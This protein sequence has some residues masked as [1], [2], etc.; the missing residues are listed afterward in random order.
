MLEEKARR[1]KFPKAVETY[2]ARLFP[3]QIAFVNDPARRKLVHAGRRGGKTHALVA[4]ILRAAVANPGTVVPVFERTTVCRA[5]DVLW[6]ALRD[7][8]DEFGLNWEFQQTLKIASLPNGCRVVIMGADTAEAADK[9]RGDGYPLVVIDEVGTF[10]QEI[11]AFL[12]KEALGPGLFD[13]G[14]RLVMAGTPNPIKKGFFFECATQG[15]WAVHHWTVLDNDSLPKNSGHLTSAERLVLRQAALALTLRE[16]SWTPTS[17]AY[18]REY[19]GQW[20]DS[21]DDRM[22][23][24]GEANLID[25]LPSAPANDWTYTL[26]IDVG[27]NDPCALVVLGRIDRDPNLYVIESYE[28]TELIP[29]ALAQHVLRLQ[30]RYTFAKMVIDTGGAG[31]GYAQE[32]RQ[33]FQLNVEPAKK[34]NKLANIEF[35]NGD[36]RTGRVKILR[37]GNKAL[38]EDLQALPWNDTKTDAAPRHRDHLPDAFLYG[39]GAVRAWADTTAARGPLAPVQGSDAWNKAQDTRMFELALAGRLGALRDEYDAVDE[40]GYDEPEDELFW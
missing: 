32:M 26:G 8:S 40:E 15:G 5:A 10:R 16:N 7:F 38:I 20:S 27:Y 31:I 14:G 21:F 30:V 33:S 13:Y 37:G 39:M 4:I 6:K 2:C 28:Q 35:V 19:L 29:S 36:L 9:G 22:Y 24:I 11:L 3:A 12:V 25:E 34:T 18:V 17:G 23:Q 1:A